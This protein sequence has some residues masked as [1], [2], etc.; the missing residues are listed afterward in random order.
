MQVWISYAQ[1]QHRIGQSKASELRGEVEDEEEQAER[2]EPTA[3][4]EAAAQAAI[5]KGLDDARNIFQRGYADLKKRSLKEERVILLEA[6][7]ALETEAEDGEQLARVEAMMPRVV[8]KRRRVDESGSMEEY[9]DLVFADDEAQ[10][11]PATS[12]LLAAA[13]A[14]KK[15]QAEKAQ[16]A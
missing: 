15:A 6:W 9:Y 16:A 13:L 3:E 2:P 4:D 12:K 5:A 7:K 14:W 11:N 8:K 10:S 1:L